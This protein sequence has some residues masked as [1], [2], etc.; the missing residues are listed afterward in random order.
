MKQKS[1]TKKLIYS[2]NLMTF[3]ALTIC[4]IFL[5]R[6]NYKNTKLNIDAQVKAVA[7]VLATSTVPLVW[8]FDKNALDEILKLTLKNEMIQRIEVKDKDLKRLSFVEKTTST[9]SASDDHRMIAKITKDSSEFIGQIEI[10]YSEQIARNIFSKNLKLFIAAI[11]LFQLFIS[12][13][14]WFFAKSIEK[15]LDQVIVNLK[16]NSS[17]TSQSTSNVKLNTST[18]IETSQLQSTALTETANSISSLKKDI[19]ENKDNSNFACQISEKS[20]LA[21]NESLTQ[22]ESLSTTIEQISK[23]S[24]NIQMLSTAIEDIAFQTNLLALNASVE[25][26]RAGE[27]GRGFSVVADSVRSLAESASKSAQEIAIHI[28]KSSELSDAVSD[29]AK[30]TKEK[31]KNIETSIVQINEANKKVN[32]LCNN[33]NTQV[34]E[35]ISL[36]DKLNTSIVSNTN[37]FSE[38]KEISE[39]LDTNVMVLNETVEHLNVFIKGA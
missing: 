14:T 24:A 29:K 28:K 34:Q 32:S 38:A 13:L 19:G 30:E 25:A 6:N 2:I 21:I 26:A 37:S 17:N 1:F 33:Q 7:D 39:D 10:S 22:L 18:L 15:D 20:V 4:A 23:S 5:L 27:N 36:L 11:V 35:V 8:N 3:S 16:M 31:F 12:T 9:N